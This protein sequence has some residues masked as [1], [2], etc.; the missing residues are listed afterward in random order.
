MKATV[1]LTALLLTSLAVAQEVPSTAPAP[2]A[3]AM[4]QLRAEAIRA[5]TRFLADDLLE[6]RAPG[7]RGGAL[8]E[9]Y[10]AAQFE[11]MGLQPAGDNGTFLQRVPLV[12]ITTDPAKTQLSFVR[13]DKSV[14]VTWLEDY[15]GDDQSQQA[16]SS[17]DS[18]LVFVG[19]GVVAPEYKWD[20]YK[21]LDARGKTLVMLV[22]DP[23]ANDKEPNLF[24]GKARTYYGRWTYKYEIARQKG[25]AA[26]I[27]IHT[28]DSAGYGW[29]VVRSSWGREQPEVGA[30]PGEHH[31][32]LA[33]WITEPVAQKLFAMSGLDLAKL[34][35]AA[36]TRKFKPVSL[37]AH[38]NGTIGSTLRQMETYNVIARLEGSDPA[39]RDEVVLYTAHHD[40]LGIGKPDETGD[41]IYNGALDNATGVALLL[42]MARAWT[43]TSPRPPR[44]IL[45]AAV[46]AEEGGLRGSEYYAA[47]PVVAPGKTALGLNFDSVEQ[48]GLVRNVMMLGV[49]RT[50]FY[51]VARRV[52]DA[53][54]LRID[55]DEHPEQGRFYRSDHFSLAK[56]GIPALSVKAG[57]DYIGS[58]PEAGRRA[59]EEYNTK[60]YH[61]PSDEFDAGWNFN[62][63]V[64]LAQLGMWL[65]W[66]AATMPELVSWVPGDEFLATRQKSLGK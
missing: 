24:G 37:G 50:T 64:Q 61:Q 47:H 63:G 28:N 2:I 4:R 3:A 23:P 54:G 48:F 16:T 56:V 15:V 8:A 9:K 51:P 5:H 39:R 35:T 45:F 26:C 65:G 12:G 14:P 38:L 22:D 32:Q 27:L 25:A 44:S 21:G 19:H 36:H 20:D 66:E 46:T 33:A 10:I 55:A 53:M 1:A 52:T 34:T 60:R 29:N 58:D 11:E 7:T 18:E 57:S 41:T 59:F 49:E 43:L 40:H 17:L 42:E 13:G 31:L 30:Q 62:E 6:G